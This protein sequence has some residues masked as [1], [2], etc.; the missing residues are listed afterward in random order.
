LWRV[1]FLGG[2]P[3]RLADNVWSAVGWFPDGRQMTFIREVGLL[4]AQALVV[5][6]S[7][8]AHERTLIQ[9][10]DGGRPSQ[11]TH[12]NDGMIFAFAWSRD[13]KRLAVLR[14]T[15]SNDIVLFRGLNQ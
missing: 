13:G 1:P 12:F 3:R 11:L 4:S 5:A 6:D 9:R 7:D 8:A 14:G 10:L 2:T 15:V